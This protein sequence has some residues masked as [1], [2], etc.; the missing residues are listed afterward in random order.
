MPRVLQ[1]LLGINRET[2]MKPNCRELMR[3]ASKQPGATIRSICRASGLPPNVVVQ[4]LESQG[5]Q[6]YTTSNRPKV[7]F[8]AA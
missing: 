6:G 1:A 8:K 2:K 4:Y 3:I 5:S 7:A